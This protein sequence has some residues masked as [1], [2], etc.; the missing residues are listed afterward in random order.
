[1]HNR[2]VIFD[3]QRFSVHDGT[4]I[5][6]TVFF[7]GCPLS[8]KWCHNPEGLTMK[9]QIYYEDEKCIHCGECVSSCKKNVHNVLEKKHTL[10][11]NNCTLCGNCINECPTRALTQ[12]GKEITVKEIIEIA[13]KDKAFYGDEGGITFSGGECTMQID[14]LLECLQ[15]AKS[16]GLNTAVDTSGYVDKVKLKQIMPYTD[17]FLYDLKA[18]SE[19]IHIKATGV[20]NKKILENFIFLCQ[21]KCNIWVRIPVVNGY[22][23]TIEEMTN[24]AEFLKGNNFLDHIELMPYHILGSNKYDNLGLLKNCDSSQIVEKDLMSNIINLFKEKELS[25]K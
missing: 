6:T 9:P 24:I 1:M 7:K 25:V 2:G 16:V 18:Y 3:I 8:C 22:N 12:I 13:L 10:D 15:T 4:G 19:K 21:N 20:S 11:Y 14:F 23:A 17:L 5:R